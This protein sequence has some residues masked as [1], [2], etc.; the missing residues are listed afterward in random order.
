MSKTT[1]FIAS[2]EFICRSCSE[3]FTYF[4]DLSWGT[5]QQNP[6]RCYA[7]KSKIIPSSRTLAPRFSSDD[8]LVNKD[9]FLNEIP[10]YCKSNEFDL[11]EGSII[12]GD[13]QEL[14]VSDGKEEINVVF[15]GRLCNKFRVGDSVE[16]TG[17]YTAKFCSNK[18][19][20]YFFIGLGITRAEG[21]LVKAGINFL[22]EWIREK[23]DFEI[24]AMV[25][26]S[27]LP[28]IYGNYHVKLALILNLL[29]KFC[30]AIFSSFIQGELSTGKSTIA[31]RLVSLFPDDLKLL[32]GVLTTGSIFSNSVI[33]NM[34]TGRTEAGLLHGDF[35]LV[36]D[37]FKFLS[38]KN[39]LLKSLEHRNVIALNEIDPCSKDF[40]DI[41]KLKRLNY[42]FD[43]FDVILNFVNY[44]RD[45]EFRKKNLGCLP[46]E[47]GGDIW[48]FDTIKQFLLARARNHNE[49]KIMSEEV[50]IL[51]E[52]FIQSQVCYNLKHLEMTLGA[53]FSVRLLESL[54][55]IA[56]LNAILLNHSEITFQDA[57]DSILLLKYYDKDRLFVDTDQYNM[58]ASETKEEIEFYCGPIFE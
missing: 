38:D 57:F 1:T 8:P 52:K 41:H 53:G 28:I 32:N 2:S 54:I 51:F 33:S 27:S 20:E 5:P 21:K 12:Y 49:I 3:T 43:K 19:S 24:R 44:E 46:Y 18:E 26:R 15:K 9:N 56:K 42:E 13:Y 30:G 37:N 58:Y 47:D 45:E 11:L 31:R 4:T 14:V 23:S 48:D 17:I 6:D 25:L 16:I 50:N 22:N 39:L 29:G 7:N 10:L 40:E 36:V 35:M 55:K 34:T